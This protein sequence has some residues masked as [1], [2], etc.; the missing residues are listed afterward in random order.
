MLLAVTVGMMLVGAA[1]CATGPSFQQ[2]YEHAYGDRT[3]PAEVGADGSDRSASLLRGLL[4]GTTKLL[5]DTTDTLL[6]TTETVV[7]TTVDTTE[8]LLGADTDEPV[9]VGPPPV[10]V[11]VKA[12][13]D[14]VR[15]NFVSTVPLLQASMVFATGN[16]D[17]TSLSGLKGCIRSSRDETLNFI[18]VVMGDGSKWYFDSYGKWFPDGYTPQISMSVGRSVVWVSSSDYVEEVLF[19]YADGNKSGSGV[20]SRGRAYFESGR[21]VSYMQVQVKY[22]KSQWPFD[23][24]GQPLPGGYLPQIQVTLGSNSLVVSSSDVYEEAIVHF[25]DGERKSFS[26]SD[27]NG[28]HR[29]DEFGARTVEAISIKLKSNSSKWYFDA[30]GALQPLSSKWYTDVD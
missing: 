25:T 13:W 10:T 30:L 12:R 21:K 28:R 4:G 5:V 11:T 1:C 14:G 8:A 7:D 27:Y 29:S 15:A 24:A 9:Q 16:V 23:R 6:D 18:E 2:E 20:D 26:N 19:Y 3:G 22:D 17:S